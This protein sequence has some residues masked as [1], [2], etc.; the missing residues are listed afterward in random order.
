MA[1][2]LPHLD[3]GICWCNPIFL[4]SCE[5][6]DPSNPDRQSCKRCNDSTLVRGD[7]GEDGEGVI[8]TVHI[9]VEEEH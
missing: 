3:E 1:R 4:V 8:L 2:D 7:W 6:C 5:A 9:E